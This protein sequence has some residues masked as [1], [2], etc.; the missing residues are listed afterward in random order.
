MISLPITSTHF[1][2]SAVS[3]LHFMGRAGGGWPI[4]GLLEAKK[5]V[6]I[7]GNRL[8]S[9]AVVLVA[10]AGLLVSGCSVLQQS[11][12]GGGE[13]YFPHANGYAWRMTGSDGS[14]TIMTVE[15]T[16]SI[17]ST[18]VQCFS[19]LYISSSNTRSTSEAYY[20]VDGSGVYAHGSPSYPSSIGIPLIQFPLEVGKTWDVMVSGSYS[21]KATVISKENMTV[22]AGTF[23][24]YKITLATTYGSSEAYTSTLWL[25]N[26]AGIVKSISSTSTVETTLA[27][28]SF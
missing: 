3:P 26:N 14:S 16:A 1:I 8:F 2:R 24:C 12:G 23:D 20:K 10:M 18:T 17:G 13:S 27:W 21:T 9:L 7:M 19:S 15:G 22:P 5:G 4:F 6:K 11:G 25:G 28:K